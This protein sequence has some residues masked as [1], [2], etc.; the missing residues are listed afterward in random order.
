[1]KSNTSE[2]HRLGGVFRYLCSVYYFNLVFIKDHI[3]PAAVVP[4][5]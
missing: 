5:Y 2:P 4:G 3:Q 1:M